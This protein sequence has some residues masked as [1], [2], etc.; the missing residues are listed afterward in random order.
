MNSLP[1]SK[2]LNHWVL[3]LVFKT[4]AFTSYAIIDHA[5]KTSTRP[6]ILPLATFKLPSYW[7]IRR[8]AHHRLRHRPTYL[9]TTFFSGMYIFSG[10]N[11]SFRWFFSARS[12]RGR[13]RLPKPGWRQLC[14]YLARKFGAN[15]Q[16]LW[17]L[18][19]L[20]ASNILILIVLFLFNVS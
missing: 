5:V 2:D 16:I 6:S 9:L 18:V 7:M 8:L 13:G 19:R 17:S 3:K 4:D 15:G 10:E 20:H 1:H 12:F 11:L 14:R